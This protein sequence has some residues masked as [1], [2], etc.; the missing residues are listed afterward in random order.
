MKLC[1]AFWIDSMSQLGA[2]YHSGN[3]RELF[4]AAGYVLRNWEQISQRRYTNGKNNQYQGPERTE[5]SNGR[6]V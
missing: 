5:K 3:D 2:A 1:R 6:E 4:M